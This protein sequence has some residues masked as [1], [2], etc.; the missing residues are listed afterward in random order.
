MA[1]EARIIGNLALDV[2]EATAPA[3]APSRHPKLRNLRPLAKVTVPLEVLELSALP[4]RGL[5]ALPHAFT[6]RMRAV[7]GSVFFLAT[8]A[9]DRQVL[10]EQGAIALD[11]DEWDA[12]TLATEADRAWP[13]DL[14]QA[15]RVRGVTGRLQIDALLDGI[16]YEQATSE[17]GPEGRGFSVGRVLARIGARM[18]EV[19]LE[20]ASR[21]EEVSFP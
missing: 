12:L 20:G 3:P 9:V 7:D 19:T 13:G 14:V 16:G 10:A 15:L 8:S 1:A 4:A 11:T 17:L 18:D 5:G 6:A 21:V 2:G